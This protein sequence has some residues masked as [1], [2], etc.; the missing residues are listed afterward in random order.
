MFQIRTRLSVFGP[1]GL[2]RPD[3]VAASVPSGL[4]ATLS[5]GAIMLV[6]HQARAGRIGGAVKHLARLRREI[7]RAP[8]RMRQAS[9][10]ASSGF[11]SSSAGIGLIGARHQLKSIQPVFGDAPADPARNAPAAT[12]SAADR[13]HDD[14]IPINQLRM[15]RSS[16]FSRVSRATSAACC[17]ARATAEACKYSRSSRVSCSRA[18]AA[19]S[20]NWIRRVPVSR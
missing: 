15:R 2:S 13:Q 16:V 17:A 6:E 20:S 3:P 12:R 18:D 7:G 19:H 11:M 1:S 14:T 10:S 8:S 4:M 9:A 5:T